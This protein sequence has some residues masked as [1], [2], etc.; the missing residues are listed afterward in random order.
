VPATALRDDAPVEISIPAQGIDAPVERV[1]LLT[2]GAMAVPQFVSDAGWLESGSAPGSVGNAVIG[3]HL[4]GITGQPGAF[5]ALGRLRSGDA[6]IVTTASGRQLR[7]AVVR[8]GRY[9][10]QAVPLV[11]VF[12]PSKEANLNLL[13]CAGPYLQDHRT[14]RDRLVVYTRL[15][16]VEPTVRGRPGDRLALES[17]PSASRRPTAAN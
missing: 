10:R 4:D 12:G 16:D 1:G 15:V 5:W 3:G 7:F 14:Y 9:D 17:I 2:N 11:A 8:T 6:I 13:T